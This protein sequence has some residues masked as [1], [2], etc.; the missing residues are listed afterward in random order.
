MQA[1]P[2]EAAEEAPRA[3]MIAAPRFCTQGMKSPVS[4][5]MVCGCG[6]FGGGGAAD[7]N[8][9][10]TGDYLV[11]FPMASMAFLPEKVLRKARGEAKKGREKCKRMRGSERR[12]GNN[13]E[14]TSD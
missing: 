2:A 12:L 1:A 10:E 3:A 5:L 6:T 14:N 11:S 4:H 9:G 7:M 8:R 13:H